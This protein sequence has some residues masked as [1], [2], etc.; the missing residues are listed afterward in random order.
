[1]SKP[2]LGL[3]YAV[4]LPRGL[5]GRVAASPEDDV[6]PRVVVLSG[7]PG[8]ER[9]RERLSQRSNH[10]WAL[11]EERLFLSFTD[12]KMRQFECERHR[13]SSIG[14]AIHD[15]SYSP[16]RRNQIPAR[17]L[18]QPD[19][20]SEREV[21]TA[22]IGEAHGPRFRVASHPAK[23]EQL[24]HEGSP[25]RS[26]DVIP[27]LGPV[28]TAASDVAR[29]SL[30]AQLGQSVRAV[31]GDGVTGGGTSSGEHAMFLEGSA[32]ETPSLPA[33]WS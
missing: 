15:Q 25:D 13:F 10:P 14:D 24:R 26:G 1:M 30:D 23:L 27:L 4:D 22:S 20:E 11:R 7:Q 31:V 5:F 19:A 32:T 2:M 6:K 33:R 29:T 17:T 16:C 8:S 12:D 21:G 18:W 28:E 9:V 3:G